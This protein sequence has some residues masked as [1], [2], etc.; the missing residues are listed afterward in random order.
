MH[1]ATLLLL[2]A[3]LLAPAAAA[4]EEP[5]WRGDRGWASSGPSI[6]AVAAPT[7]LVQGESVEVSLNGFDTSSVRVILRT[8][9]DLTV[10]AE[11]TATLGENDAGTFDG[12]ALLRVPR[13]A[14]PG[15]VEIGAEARPGHG[16][17][18]GARLL[19]GPAVLAP[20]AAPPRVGERA[21]L[22]AVGFDADA[23][24]VFIVRQANATWRSTWA[25][26]AM[27]ADHD[28]P[29]MGDARRALGGWNG[30]RGV[31]FVVL[32]RDVAVRIEGMLEGHPHGLDLA[33]A[34][35]GEVPATPSVWVEPA[36][37]A[38][39]ADLHAL[40]R[41]YVYGAGFTGPVRVTL[42]N[43]SATFDAA[44]GV[45]GGWL[46]LGPE[47][48]A[49]TL[50]AKDTEGREAAQA[51]RVLP[52]QRVAAAPMPADP[53][54]P[55]RSLPLAPMLALAAFALAAWRPRP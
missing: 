7:L 26:G 3:T 27:D 33:W 8:Q 12:A 5:L 49:A 46:P 9:P 40:G 25:P 53:T 21:E 17:F 22:L 31:A 16:A 37:A 44:D 4:Q 41:A 6:P 34:S 43:A 30:P 52:P 51:V 35:T 48:G 28:A 11:A 19:A 42:H 10:L 55:A 1:S 24:L 45:F 2:L 38:F 14:P 29:G 18:L 20:Q 15:A 54:P 13:D 50:V 47:E 39:A 36:H 32:A 23:P